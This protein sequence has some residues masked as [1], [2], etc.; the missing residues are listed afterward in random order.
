MFN[1]KMDKCP[2]KLLADRYDELIRHY[3]Y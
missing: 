1:C 3:S 2:I